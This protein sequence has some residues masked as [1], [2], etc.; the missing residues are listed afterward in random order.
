MTTVEAAPTVPTR[1]S[2]VAATLDALCR[3][4]LGGPLPVRL[5]A[6]DGSESGPDDGPTVV[7]RSPQAL[8]RLLWHPGE[9]GLAQAYVTGDLDVE[10]DLA[11]GFR[12]I[13]RAERQENVTARRPS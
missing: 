6:W 5:G 8:R 2:G 10:G 9:L 3:E 11:D 4:M 13:W 7:L 12:R 1:T